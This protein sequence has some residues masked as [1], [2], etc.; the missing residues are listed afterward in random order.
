V[1]AETKRFY[2]ES[3]INYTS[4]GDIVAVMMDGEATVKTFSRKGGHIW[5]LP[6]NDNF[7]PIDGDSCEVLGKVTAVLR[8]I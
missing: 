6:A 2:W 7:A 8:S 3:L 5:L 4:T 1:D